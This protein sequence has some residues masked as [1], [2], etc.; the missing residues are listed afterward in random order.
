MTDVERKSNRPARGSVVADWFEGN[1]PRAALMRWLLEREAAQK[2][3]RFGIDRRR[4]LTSSMG[5]VAAM[6]V[7]Q[8][9]S[10]FR[11][12]AEAQQM[13]SPSDDCYARVDE[14][15]AGNGVARA[16]FT[17]LDQ[18]SILYRNLGGLRSLP[19]RP[20]LQ[21]GLG[22]SAVGFEREIGVRLVRKRRFA[23]FQDGGAR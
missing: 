10:R 23:R 11:S 9:A 1:T 18:S 22:P 14:L 13:K 7:V 4:F 21:N 5:A 15:H 12:R 3:A 20:A 16:A 6:A 17:R 19:R 2:S 8:Q